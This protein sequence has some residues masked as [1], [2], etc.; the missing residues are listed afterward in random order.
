MLCVFLLYSFLVVYY[1]IKSSKRGKFYLF[2]PLIIHLHFVFSNIYPLIVYEKS[3]PDNIVNVTI[4]SCIIN[5]FLLIR[6]RSLWNAKVVLEFPEIIKG[7]K[8]AN[9]RKVVSILFL[10]LIFISGFVTGV[11][12]AILRGINVEDMRRSAE[13][14]IGFIREIPS[15]GLPILILEYFLIKQKISI[16]KSMLI[17]LAISLIYFLATGHRR[18]V[19][20]YLT[21]FLVWFN[22]K[23]RNFKWYEYFAI[24]YLFQPIIATIMTA[25]RSGADINSFS[26]TLFEHERMIFDTNTILLARWIE[27]TNLYL[28]GYS[29]FYGLV[30]FIPRFLW[31]GKPVSIDYYYKEV[32]GLDFEGG[33]I[34][35]T[36]DFEL[37]LNFGYYY[38]LPYLLFMLIPH[39]VY[40]KMCKKGMGYDLRLYFIVIFI[41]GWGLIGFIKMSE[42]YILFLIIMFFFNR[43]WRLY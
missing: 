21:V 6:Y 14:G 5:L 41:Y 43:K 26:F 17:V 3:L 36:S 2:S 18:G 35:T 38:A 12:P 23:Y 20:V 31:P 7:N 16:K 37:Y 10:F 34:Y 9:T 33:G 1:I 22:F 15:V 13:V 29:Y 42:L 28:F 27:N 24:F 40:K 19:A 4:I 11:T 8:Y 30:Y 39:I 32:V 25:I